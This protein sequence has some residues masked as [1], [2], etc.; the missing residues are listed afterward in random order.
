KYSIDAESSRTRMNKDNRQPSVLDRLTNQKQ[1]K[2]IT[3]KEDAKR[4]FKDAIVGAEKRSAADN[5]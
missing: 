3:F 5:Y 2:T 1:D 4:S